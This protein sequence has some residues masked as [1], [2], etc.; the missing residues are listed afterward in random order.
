MSFLDESEPLPSPTTGQLFVMVREHGSR[1]ELNK[2]GSV[3]QD[4]LRL[5]KIPSCF[6]QVR[7]VAFV[8]DKSDWSQV[9]ELSFFLRKTALQAHSGR[10]LD[11]W[12]FREKDRRPSR[13]RSEQKKQKAEEW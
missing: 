4:R 12:S 1:I 8:C 3:L 2:Y 7:L 11:L 10:R 9:E 6:G 5:R 13:Q